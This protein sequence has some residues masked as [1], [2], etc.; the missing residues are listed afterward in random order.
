MWLLHIFHLGNCG[1]ARR[2]ARVHKDCRENHPSS[3]DVSVCVWCE[4]TCV[5]GVF[6][7]GV[8]VCVHMCVCRQCVH[9]HGMW[10]GVGVYMGVYVECMYVGG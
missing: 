3:G 4:C 2:G 1:E 8:C 6:V 7:C 5:C 9:V 10:V